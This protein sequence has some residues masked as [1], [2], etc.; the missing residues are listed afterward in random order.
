MGSETRPLTVLTP[1]NFFDNDTW[2]GEALVDIRVEPDFSKHVQYMPSVDILVSQVFTAEMAEQ[3]RRL[4]FI[5]SSG[6]G[7]EHIDLSAVPL[8]CEVAVVFEHER[9]IAEWILMA[10]VALNRDVLIADQALRRQNWDRSYFRAQFPPELSSQTLAIIGLGHIGR[11]AA[12]VARAMGMRLVAATRTPPSQA[13]SNHLGLSRCV[14]LEHMAEVVAEADF[15]LVALASTPETIGIIGAREL[16]RMKPDGCLINVARA[17]LVDE[18]S[19]YDAL[20]N[21]TIKGAALDVWYSE[22]TRPDDHPKPSAYPFAELDNVLMTPHLS[23]LTSDMAR[24]RLDFVVDNID[25]FARGE[26]L[27]N[28]LHS[29]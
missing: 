24:G 4:R 8:G 14:R 18:A 10:M 17:N 19:L 28:V 5:Q 22:P 16:A 15:V 7:T 9:A 13:E 25:R 26:P 23:G 1:F 21:R 6:A 11:Q 27:L 20:R 3:S 2:P 29:G 12:A